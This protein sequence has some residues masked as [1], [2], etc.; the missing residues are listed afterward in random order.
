MP[1]ATAGFLDIEGLL[2]GAGPWALA[3]VCA[4]IFVE[5]GLLV[6]FLLPGDTLLVI[7]GVLVY[8]G[9]IDVPLWIVCLA[10][11][12]S[13]F[14][15]DQLGYWIGLKGGPALFEKKATGFFSRESIDRTNRFFVRFGGFAVTISRFIGVV[16]TITPVAAGVGRMPYG[17]FVVYNALGGLVWG[18]GLTFAGWLVAHIPVVRDFVTEYLEF[19][20]LGVIALTI[21]VIATHW[22]RMRLAVRREHRL[23][24]DTT[25]IETIDLSHLE[26]LEHH[27]RHE[28][29]APE[30]GRTDSTQV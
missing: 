1:L 10:I 20:L 5:S 17:R 9:F 26:T 21:G 16:R 11:F 7:T 22:V 23:G 30:R 4:I 28:S 13:A 8:Q 29:G 3:V 18:A 27:G 15:G 14:L 25:P 12:V 24:L 2:H 19:V 6:G